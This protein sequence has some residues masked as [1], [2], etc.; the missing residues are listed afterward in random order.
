MKNIKQLVTKFKKFTQ[1]EYVPYIPPSI[2]VENFLDQIREY[3]LLDQSQVRA[4]WNEYLKFHNEKKYSM[5]LGE[6][7]TLS[8]E[9]AFILYVVFRQYRPK[10]VIEIGTQYGKSTR[11]LID[12]HK[13][14]LSSNPNEIVCFDVEDQVQFFEKNE[15]KLVLKDVTNSAQ[16]TILDSFEPGII[17]LDAHPYHLLKNVIRAVIDNGKWI[18]AIHDC[19]PGLC[20]PKMKLKKDDL[21][22]TS[23][24]GHWERHVLAEIFGVRDVLSNELNKLEIK[25]HKLQIFDTPHGLAL[26]TPKSVFQE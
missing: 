4:M 6:R 18:I 25:T 13:L 11:R 19:A 24:T 10:S 7:K 14:T 5:L 17:Y 8:M 12:M 26:I 2:N 21:N 20:N 15:A 9:E 23:K 3:F 1:K 22:I 16:Q